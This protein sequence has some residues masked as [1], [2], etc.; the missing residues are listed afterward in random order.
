MSNKQ[1]GLNYERKEKKY[2]EEK[3]AYVNRSRGSFG[4]F[5]MIVA[6]R[7]YWYLVSVKSTKT[8]KFS[9]KKHIDE[10]KAFDKAPANTIKL[11]V[12]YNG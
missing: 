1:Y 10:I 12:F 3:G 2:W 11:F 8:G 6:Y 5:D 4:L 9:H 7:D